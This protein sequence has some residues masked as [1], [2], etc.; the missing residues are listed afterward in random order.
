M[1]N[2]WCSKFLASKNDLVHTAIAVKTGTL[3][4][5]DIV[6][7]CILELRIITANLLSTYSENIL[8]FIEAKHL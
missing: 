7:Q 2:V 3:S 4:K 6:L 5:Y 1:Y 8:I